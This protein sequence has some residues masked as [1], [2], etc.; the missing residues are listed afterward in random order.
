MDNIG[1]LFGREIGQYWNDLAAWEEV[2]NEN[3]QFESIIEIGTWQGGMSY[4]LSTQA[5]ARGLDFKTFDINNPQKPV[6]YFYKGDVFEIGVLR[7]LECSI[8]LCDGGN[9]SKEAKLCSEILH[10]EG[11]IAVHDWETEFHWYDIPKGYRIYKLTS[12]TV[13]LMRE[14]YLNEREVTDG[15][16][17]P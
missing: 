11:C 10:K 8:V 14:D 4:F 15:R 3:P 12:H 9:K 16:R 7:F 1:S 6:P 5:E 13:F 2:L 17:Y